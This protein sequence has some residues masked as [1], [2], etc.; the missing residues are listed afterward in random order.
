MSFAITGVNYNLNALLGV[1]N[2]QCQNPYYQDQ[3]QNQYLFQP[4]SPCSPPA[5]NAYNFF[6]TMDVLDQACNSIPGF[7]NLNNIVADNESGKIVGDPHFIGA[8]GGR[9]DVQGQ[10]GKTYSLLSD[11]LLDF[12]G[13]FDAWGNNGATVVGETAINVSN[14]GGSE[15]SN[16]SFTKDGV[17]KV[18]G[19][20]IKDGETVML[21]DGGSA[22]LNGNKLTVQTLEG[23]TIIQEAIKNGTGNYI[24]TEVKT[25]ALGVATDNRL[26]GGLLGQTFDADDV[27]KNGKR[28]AG[29][30]GEGAI[31]GVVGD[32]ET[33]LN[34]ISDRQLD[35]NGK[36]IVAENPFADVTNQLAE[37]INPNPN[38]HFL[39][40]LS[41]V[42][43]N[44]FAILSGMQN[45]YQTN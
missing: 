3:Y 39:D 41:F 42:M 4:V 26:P 12:N 37:L 31:A 13:R 30:Q 33:T 14:L 8:D 27:A 23:Y 29:A 28:G 25:G 22:T 5:Q 1:Q 40:V 32:Y 44:I 15:F 16:V 20:E 34:T 43:G 11:S 38:K 9:F 36:L 19:Q 6:G 21:A 24:N 7:S 35:E 45:Q 10:P 18:N 2:S 17:A